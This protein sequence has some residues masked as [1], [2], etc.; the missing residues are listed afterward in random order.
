MQFAHTIIQ[1][2]YKIE[3]STIEFLRR[4]RRGW[5]SSEQARPKATLVDLVHIEESKEDEG[6]E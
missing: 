1:D 5:S 6:V 4:H 3:T 2:I